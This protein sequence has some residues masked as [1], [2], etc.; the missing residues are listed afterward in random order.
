MS[1]NST[2][3]GKNVL[4]PF[5]LSNLLGNSQNEG[6]VTD[7]NEKMSLLPSFPKFFPPVCLQRNIEIIFEML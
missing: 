1:S 4:P 7:E 3:T 6:S 2:A 5:R